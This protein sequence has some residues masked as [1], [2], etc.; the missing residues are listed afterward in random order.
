MKRIT[1]VV[2]T[3]LAFGW[4]SVAHAYIVDLYE[5]TGDDAHVQMDITGD[6]TNSITFT[7]KILDPKINDVPYGDIT[8]VWFNFNPFPEYEDLITVTGTH[9]E[10]DNWSFKENLADLPEYAD[11]TPVTGWDAGILIGFKPGNDSITNTTFTITS[12]YPEL[13]KLGTY[14]GARLKSTPGVEG[15]SKL[16]GNYNPIPEPGTMLL[17]GTGLAGLA[18]VGRRRKN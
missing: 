4:V 18:A 14:F 1:G 10:E 15:S 8:A 2:A 7:V 12:N 9:V 16:V 5:F 3:V 6:G 13:L 17:F 11:L